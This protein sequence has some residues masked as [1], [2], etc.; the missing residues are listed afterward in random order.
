MYTKAG[1]ETMKK[2]QSLTID[3]A[4]SR[5]EDRETKNEAALLSDALPLQLHHVSLV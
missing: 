1:N 4:R 3:D 5:K 2:N